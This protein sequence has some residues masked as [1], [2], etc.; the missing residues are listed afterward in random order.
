MEEKEQYWEFDLIGPG[1]AW[2]VG[3]AS[4][5]W[6]AS[7]FPRPPCR[8]RP[9][10]PTPSARVETVRGNISIVANALTQRQRIAPAGTVCSISLFPVVWI[11]EH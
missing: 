2:E 1:S 10:S 6:D 9:P 11:I 4:V 3:P 5:G 8:C 7:G